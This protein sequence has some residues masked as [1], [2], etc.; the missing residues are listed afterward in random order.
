MGSCGIDHA[1]RGNL[2]SGTGK[3]IEEIRPSPQRC[4][5]QLTSRPGARRSAANSSETENGQPEYEVAMTVNGR[6][7][8]VSFAADGRT[9][10]I[11]QEVL[12]DSLPTAVRSRRPPTHRGRSFQLRDHPQKT[13]VQ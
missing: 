11:E 1:A 6:S 13:S 10:E 2:V 5:G 7:R 3:A 4:R 9:L 8:D 12:G